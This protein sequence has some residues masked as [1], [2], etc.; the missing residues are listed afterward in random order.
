[1]A[2]RKTDRRAE[3][4]SM[5]AHEILNLPAEGFTLDQLRYNYK[6]LARQLHPDK[7]SPCMSSQQATE[8]FQVLTEAYR[9]LVKQLDARVVDKTHDELRAASRQAWS[10]SPAYSAAD[11]ADADAEAGTRS[12]GT[13]KMDLERFNAI[14]D[15]NRMSDP[16]V[17]SGYGRWMEE[18]DPSAAGAERKRLRQRQ[19]QMVQYREPVP[20]PLVAGIAYSEL[21]ETE[22]H[23]YSRSD[24]VAAARSIQ[25]T[26]YRLA[27][28]TDKLV[29]EEDFATLANRPDVGGCVL[30]LKA[31]R[32]ALSYEMS[33]ADAAA[34]ERALLELQLADRRRLENMRLRDR[35]VE[36]TFERTSR[37][38][39]EQGRRTYAP[40]PPAGKPRR[41]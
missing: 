18:S 23:D 1:M 21:G 11:E 4:T 40:S 41:F 30:K 20:T 9:A 2:R 32:A 37:L 39:L 34:E 10:A 5:E 25:Y 26:D 15:E 36:S 16:V 27:H 6:A 33:D 19:Q 8:M 14:F 22:R 24:G 38:L 7:R 35:A 13:D 3:G 29:D 31:Q 12:S 17:D 28:T